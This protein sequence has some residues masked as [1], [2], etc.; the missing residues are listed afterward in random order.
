MPHLEPS[1]GWEAAVMSSALSCGD[2]RPAADS[3]VGPVRGVDQLGY[4]GVASEA[5]RHLPR[6]LFVISLEQLRRRVLIQDNVLG[7]AGHQLQVPVSDVG[8]SSGHGW[9]SD[10]DV[11]ALEL[12]FQLHRTVEASDL[13]SSSGSQPVAIGAQGGAIDPPGLGSDVDPFAHSHRQHLA[14]FF[15]KR[16]VDLAWCRIAKNVC[17]FCRDH[18][19]EVIAGSNRIACVL[20]ERRRIDYPFV[21][22]VVRGPSVARTLEQARQVCTMQPREVLPAAFF[23]QVVPGNPQPPGGIKPAYAISQKKRGRPFLRIKRSESQPTPRQDA[24]SPREYV[25]PSFDLQCTA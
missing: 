22:P 15:R 19:D 6:H 13:D 2:W 12:L 5:Q 7:P 11:A 4:H 21:R 23:G 16:G 14:P 10:L 3:A 24:G 1:P 25:A 9:Q 18:Q 8:W 20:D 17:I